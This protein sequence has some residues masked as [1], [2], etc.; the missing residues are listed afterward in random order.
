MVQTTKKDYC[1]G[2]ESHETKQERI[3]T[4][5]DMVGPHKRSVSPAKAKYHT[6]LQGAKQ[7]SLVI[8]PV[9]D[10]YHLMHHSDTESQ[11]RKQESMVISLVQDM[12][13]N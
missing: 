5:Q 13:V 10:M 11:G 4:N 1:H 9:H 3:V 2:T 6:E 12:Q 7:E 8:S